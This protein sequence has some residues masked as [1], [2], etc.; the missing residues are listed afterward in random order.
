MNSSY[1]EV[2]ITGPSGATL[3][4]GLKAATGLYGAGGG[5][6]SIVQAP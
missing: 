1:L 3:G 6:T 2:S 4:A 5:L